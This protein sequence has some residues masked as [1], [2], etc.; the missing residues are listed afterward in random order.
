MSKQ[1]VSSV[2]IAG[3]G[4]MGSAI[5]YLIVTASKAKVCLYDNHPAALKK[6][7]EAFEQFAK[8]GLEKNL[9][10]AELLADARS[11]LTTIDNLNK[12]P[13]SELVI[14][15]IAEDLQIKK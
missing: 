15:A 7:G 2:F 11:N 9:I 4:F 14:E 3:A 8:K 13:E 10:T 1:S 5:A 6:A 12:V